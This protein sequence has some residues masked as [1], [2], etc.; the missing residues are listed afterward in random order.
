MCTYFV[1]ILRSSFLSLNSSSR[2]SMAKFLDLI[3]SFLDLIS[4]FQ[5]SFLKWMSSFKTCSFLL[6]S[7]L[8]WISVCRLWIYEEKFEFSDSRLWIIS[9]WES[10]SEFF[11]LRTSMRFWT[12]VWPIL[13]SFSF[14]SFYASKLVIYFWSLANS[15]KC[16]PC[17]IFPSV[18][19][20]S[21]K[22]KRLPILLF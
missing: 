11:V 9:F 17:W 19:K 21:M 8:S 5:L 16:F 4:S 22:F 14:T 1:R 18:T 20:T 12:L 15:F 7:F 13:K 2:F 3:V 10:H 6:T